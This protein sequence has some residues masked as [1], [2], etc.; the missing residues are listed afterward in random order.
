[1][2]WIFANAVL[3]LALT[4]LIAIKLAR[5]ADMLNRSE[6][7][8]AGF[9]GSA[10]FLTIPIILNGGNGTPFEGWASAL[11]TLGALVYFAGRMSRHIRHRAR[12]DAQKRLAEEHM[13]SR[14]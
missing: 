1:M 9:M 11:F 8:G 14:Q 6:R 3:R 4:L 12:N 2:S 13:A 7:L 10:S 5:Y